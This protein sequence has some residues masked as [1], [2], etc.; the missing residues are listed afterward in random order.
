MQMTEVMNKVVIMSFFNCYKVS[1]DNMDDYLKELG[2]GMMG[3]MMAKGIKPRLVISEKDGKWSLRTETTLKIMMIE[4]T[5]NVEYEETTGDGRELKV[6]T[7][8]LLR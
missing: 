1:S 4:F 8:T 3:R 6:I 2:V 5:P 7:M